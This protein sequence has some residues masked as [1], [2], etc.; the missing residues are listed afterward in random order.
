MVPNLSFAK[1]PK[2]ADV[3]LAALSPETV[4][5]FAKHSVDGGFRL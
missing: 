3:A 2:L 4:K 1:A 5:M